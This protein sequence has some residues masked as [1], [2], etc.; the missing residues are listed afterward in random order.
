MLLS[1]E[2]RHV[3]RQ[4]R[5]HAA[6][7]IFVVADGVAI[8]GKRRKAERSQPRRKARVDKRC[9]R[10]GQVNSRLVFGEFRYLAKVRSRKRK[11]AGNNH[12]GEFELF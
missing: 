11:L 6:A 10:F 2:A 4:R 9:L 1:E 8:G 7:L 5:Y 12:A 3:G